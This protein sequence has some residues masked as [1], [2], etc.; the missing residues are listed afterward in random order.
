MTVPYWSFA[1]VTGP[2]RLLCSTSPGIFHAHCF[3]DVVYKGTASIWLH[4]CKNEIFTAKEWGHGASFVKTV[5]TAVFLCR[6]WKRPQQ[7][8][9]THRCNMRRPV[10][11]ESSQLG[12]VVGSPPCISHLDHLKKLPQP[13]TL[14]DENDR[15]GTINHWWFSKYLPIH[16]WNLTW[17]LKRSLWKRRFLLETIIFR[18]HVKFW[19]VPKKGSLPG[20]QKGDSH[21]PSMTTEIPPEVPMASRSSWARP[22]Q[23]DGM[24]FWGGNHDLIIGNL[25]APPLMQRAY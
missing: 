1:A 10:L 17:N 14:G 4:E 2:E 18:F 25:R 19:G 23:S 15:H 12:S 13:I 22:V 5:A 7:L 8:D 11:G 9:A 24:F 20:R 6:C 3:G 21:D 16:P